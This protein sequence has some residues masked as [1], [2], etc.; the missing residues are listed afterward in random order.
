M[1]NKSLNVLK[2]LTLDIIQNAK[3][4]HPGSCLSGASI[5]YTLFTKHLKV[6]PS[7]PEWVN[8]DRF[9]MS[10]GHASALLYAMMFLSG[11]K[12]NIEDL[13]NYRKL[14]S[15]TPGHP[16]ISTLG[17]E[18]TTGALGEGFATSVG[19]ALAEKIYEN[20]FNRKPKNFF[21]KKTVPLVDYYTYVY[22]S[23]GDLMEG[24]SYEAASFAGNMNLG[25]LI[26]L[27][28]SNKFTMDK[29]TSETFSEDVL[30]RFSSM[31]WHTQYVKN[32]NSIKDISKAIEKAKSNKINPS[33]IKIDTI[34]GSG[35]KYQGTNKIH[36]GELEKEDFEQIRLKLG[37]DGMP[38]TILKEPAE[39]IRNQVVNRGL[40]EFE[41]YEKIYADYK[42]TMSNDQVTEYENI[43]FNRAF[44]ELD[45]VQ[46][47]INYE[48][49]ELLRD[50]NQ[51]VMNVISNI[52]PT[53]IGGSADTV[54]STKTYLNGAGDLNA[55][56][57]LGKNIAFGVRENLMGAVLNG[58]ALSGFRP[59]GSTFLAFSDYMKPSI[60][61]SALMNLPV[62]YIFTHDSIT[63]ASDG[64]THEPVE[65]LASLRSIPNLYVYRPA[66]IK[67]IIGTYNTILNDKKP[68][69]ISLARTEVKAQEGTKSPLVSKGAYIVSKENER[70]DLILLATGAEV[71]VAISVKE[72]L[73]NEG[74]DVRVVSMP[75]MEKYDEQSEG[76]KEELFPSGSKIFVIEYGSS[77][78]WEKF[79]PS[80]DYLFTVDMFGISASKDDVLNYCKVS[81][82]D[83]IERIKNLI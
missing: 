6:N 68:S 35:S 15:N 51:K 80:S 49:K 25:K 54:T 52:L 11:Y 36:S 10:A 43:S 61:M 3:G 57:Y 60:R 55:K 31:G 56:N 4:G 38:F 16:E 37:I 39:N 77:F 74:I 40:A 71:Q 23:D 75:C 78:G 21:D 8:R 17:V 50:S 29:S 32:G 1:D 73:K 18:V 72:R 22:V 76:Y 24:I 28:D 42:T 19:L 33:I 45:K 70:I 63:V 41:K 64:P 5:L 30:S 62:T 13:K 59:F 14:N 58:L 12:F 26:V 82:E 81:V 20:K 69:V 27:Y 66:D 83:I 46:I 47:D 53:F 65:Q 34:I 7:M 48:N 79:V 9:V 67:E 44:V 2:G